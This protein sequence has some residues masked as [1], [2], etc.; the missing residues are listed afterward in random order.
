M[1]T[2]RQVPYGAFN[3]LVT[4]DGTSPIGG[5]SDVSGLSTEL[6]V[7]EYRAGISKVNHVQKVQ[8]LH[9]VGDVTLKRG[10]IDSTD[11]FAWIEQARVA[12]PAAKRT[13]VIALLDETSTLKQQ[14]TLTGCL[15]LKYTAPTFAAKGSGDV[16]ME[17][18]V[19]SFEGLT[20]GALGS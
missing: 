17:E 16:A 9:K 10:V 18:L 11:F 14:W 7:A 1:A 4:I 8:G 13:L 19:I 15:P 12:G 3:F 20:L 5:F 2:T 6:V